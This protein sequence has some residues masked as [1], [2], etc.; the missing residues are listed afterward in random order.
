MS[1]F[2]YNCLYIIESL[3]SDEF[4]TGTELEKYLNKWAPKQGINCQVITYQVHSKEEWE[5]TWNGIYTNMTNMCITPIIHLEMHGNKSYLGIDGGTNG[6]IPLAEVFKKVQR[7]N[8]I[9]KNRIFLTL[10]VCMGLNMI[11]GL[12]VY[13]PMPFCGVLGFLETLRC[14]ELLENYTTFYK[15][16]LTHQNLDSA[17]LAMKQAGI[18]SNKYELFKPEQIFLNS[19]LAYLETYKTDKQIEERALLQ[20]KESGLV[21]KNDKEQR[22]FIRKYRCTLLL[23][24][25]VEYK[26]AIKKFF[27]LDQYQNNRRI[28]FVPKNIYDFKQKAA[29]SG[30]QWLLERRPL[31]NDDIKELSLRILKEVDEFCS[32]N[33]IHYSLAYGTLIGA[34]RHKGYIPWDDDIDIMMLRPD[35]DRFISLFNH[36]TSKLF[37]VASSVS[38]PEFHYP[39]AKITC[40]S[41]INNEYGYDRYGYAIDLFPIDKIPETDSE[42]HFIIWKKKI[43]WNLFLL[44]ALTWDRKRSLKTNLI[45]LV[46]KLF[47]GLIPYSFIHKRMLKESIRYSGLKNYR[48]GSIFSPYGTRDFFDKELFSDFNLHPFENHQFSVIKGFDKYL[49]KIYGDYMKLP[50]VEQQVTHHQFIPYWK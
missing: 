48:L 18:N 24:E 37:S 8:I 4:Q 47:V 20:A 26:K 32:K 29:E 43:C 44:K 31:T 30:H 49:T 16:F 7:A 45:I 25:D 46:L 28:F 35:Y 10:A 39:I 3:K 19:Y 34:I 50:P 2:E 21:F 1:S 27:Q 17:E 13:E 23:S 41:T 12:N 22:R 36:D 38:D 14:D 9:S 5:L 11:R 6:I 33:C 15:A 42:S 40:N